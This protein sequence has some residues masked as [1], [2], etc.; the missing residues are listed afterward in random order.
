ML[1]LHLIDSLSIS[2]AIKFATKHGDKSNQ[3]S[4]G[5]SLSMCGLKWRMCDMQY[6]VER[7]IVDNSL[8]S[9]EEN[10]F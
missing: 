2:Y 9:G 6:T 3:W 4:L 1:K 7:D 8:T 5:L 10:C